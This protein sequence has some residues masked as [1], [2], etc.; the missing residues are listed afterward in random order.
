MRERSQVE[1]TAV[2]WVADL[3]QEIDRHPVEVYQSAEMLNRRG[4]TVKTTDEARLIT[5]EGKRQETHEGELR[6]L[7]KQAMLR[8]AVYFR[9]NDRSPDELATD[10]TAPST[11][12][13][14]AS[15]PPSSTALAMP[16]RGCRPKTWRPCSRR[17][18]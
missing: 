15:C 10:L 16:R 3:T 11:A 13:W 9:G 5:E 8:G 1:T 14:V 6:R 17:T 7:L 12:C 2:F 18:I 4:R